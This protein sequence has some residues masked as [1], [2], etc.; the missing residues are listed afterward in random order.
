[1]LGATLL[2]IRQ[3]DHLPYQSRNLA[4]MMALL[5]AGVLLWVW[6][7]A[8][9]RAPARW[10]LFLGGGVLV[11]LG[12]GAALFRI[13]GVSG[14]LMPILEPRW[15]RAPAREEPPVPRGALPP[16]PAATATSAAGEPAAAL[17]PAGR[18]FPQFLGPERN[19]VLPGLYLE[20]DW[21]A[22]PPEVV[23]RRPVG[24]AWSGFAVVGARAFTQEQEGEE[25]AVT[26]YELA[27]GRLLWR[28]AARAR[29]FT[30]LAGEGPRCTPTVVSN[31]VLALGATG[32]LHCLDPADGRLLWTRQI[33]ADA[34]SEVPE[35]GRFAAGD[36]G[37]GGGQCRRAGGPFPLGLPA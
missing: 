16:S 4:S 6:W 8:G 24:A 9:S 14:D 12:L 36:R 1:M 33:T 20:P 29:Y 28:Q 25:E 35:W 19:G 18:D 22:H 3:L 15:R 11:V 30:T 21:A 27:T 23:W 2:V 5:V 32:L 37:Q 26:C 7:V 17:P 13:G 34:G 10:R 31:R